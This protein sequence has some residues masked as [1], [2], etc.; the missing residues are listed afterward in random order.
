MFGTV[1]FLFL[2]ISVIIQFL[3]MFTKDNA[4]YSLG[5]IVLMISYF[6]L[7]GIF[8]LLGWAGSSNGTNAITN[9][10]IYI[11]KSIF[12]I[13]KF[14]LVHIKIISISSLLIFCF[15]AVIFSIIDNK[16]KTIK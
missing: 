3:G 2:F 1:F 16:P 9:G 7:Y 8:K 14:F 4:I 6:P 11:F 5:G 12:Y 15:I 10:L 13:F